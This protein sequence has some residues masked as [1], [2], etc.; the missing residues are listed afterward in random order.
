MT[1]RARN[2]WALKLGSLLLGLIA[3]ATGG[4]LKAADA[5][6]AECTSCHE[7]GAK[8]AKSAHAAADLRHLPRIARQI[9]ASRQHCK[10][11]LRR[12]PH[13]PGGRLRPGRPR[14]GAQGRQ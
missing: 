10:A 5:P 11:R 7:Q 14:A 3:G 1:N 6:K 12:L 9:S 13:R 8:L 2:G 4:N